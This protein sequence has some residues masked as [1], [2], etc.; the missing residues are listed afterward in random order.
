MYTH[1]SKCKNSKINFS[2]SDIFNNNS[3]SSSA[4]WLLPLKIPKAEI[5]LKYSIVFLALVPDLYVREL[6]GIVAVW[7]TTFQAIHIFSPQD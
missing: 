4:L 5:C 6:T 3:N 2:K 7:E 1:V